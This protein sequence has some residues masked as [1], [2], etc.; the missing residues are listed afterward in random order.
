V[1]EEDEELGY[2]FEDGE[3]VDREEKLKRERRRRVQL[4]YDDETGELVPRR[5]RKRDEE[6]EDWS[7]YIEF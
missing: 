6:A 4:V 3:P 2:L 1:T 7:E 5:R